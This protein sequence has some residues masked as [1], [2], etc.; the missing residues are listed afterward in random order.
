MALAPIRSSFDIAAAAFRSW[1]ADRAMRLGAGLAYYS[2]FALVPLL[3]L[4]VSFAGAVFGSDA[5]ESTVEESIAEFLGTDAANTVTEAIDSVRVE[6]NSA[7]L[8]LL[9]LGALVFTASLLFV[10]WKEMVDVI[11]GTARERGVQGTFT[12]RVF[13]V[14][15]VGA[16]GLLLVLVI[17]AETVL[18][19]IGQLSDGLVLDT[20]LRFGGTVAPVVLG[21]VFL[22]LL[23]RLSP[24]HVVPW[25]SV[26]PAAI[27]TMVMLSVGAWA[28]G[29]YVATFGFTSASGVAGTVLLGLVAIYY[30]AQILLYG[31]EVSKV[32][33]D[34]ESDAADTVSLP[35]N[36][37]SRSRADSP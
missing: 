7:V 35:S 26:W 10:A 1:S 33:T 2:L 14:A 9:S 25:R 36:D 27:I 32:I 18:S 34:R 19:A 13:G 11:W 37:E 24:K 29:L 12:R 8:P 31:V 15:A 21:S 20:V 22:A 30:A 16:S 23:F 6:R 3:F 5:A 28:Y 17:L 4:A